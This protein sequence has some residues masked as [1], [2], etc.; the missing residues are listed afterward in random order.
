MKGKDMMECGRTVIILL[1]LIQG[2][3][4]QGKII[5]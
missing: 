1:L 2:T 3:S 4:G 5:L